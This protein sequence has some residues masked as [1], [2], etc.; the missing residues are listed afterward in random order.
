MPSR[1]PR[2]MSARTLPAPPSPWTPPTA[3]IEWQSM[4]QLAPNC[5]CVASIRL[6][7]HGDRGG[8]S[9]R[10]AGG[11]PRRRGGARRSAG[12]RRGAPDQG[13]A[14]PGLAARPVLVRPLAAFDQLEVDVAGMPVVVDVGARH[15]RGEQANAALGRRLPELVDVAILAVAQLELADRGAEVG[16]EVDPRMRRVED[17]RR[18]RLGRPVQG[19]GRMRG[20]HGDVSIALFPA[21]SQPLHITAERERTLR[22]AF[23]TAADAS[24]H[25][26]RVGGSSRSKCN[27]SS[28]PRWRRRAAS[29]ASSSA[30]WSRC[31]PRWRWSP[32]RRPT[33][34]TPRR[35]R[36]RARTSTSSSDDP[37]S[38]GCR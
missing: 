32:G 7:G 4:C 37:A 23:A 10:S 29:A 22:I 31:S 15:A 2:T 28:K 35:A 5:A 9:A 3:F 26:R 24:L 25:A 6:P 14:K 12:R 34:T 1:S 27:A 20:G 36:P 8:D 19:E 30:C 33:P 18:S 11:S 13:L 38:T 21:S 17:Q 16:R